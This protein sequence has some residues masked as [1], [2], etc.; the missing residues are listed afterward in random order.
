MKKIII[1]LLLGFAM[2]ACCA[3]AAKDEAQPAAPS[4]TPQTE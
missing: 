2:T 1:L 4:G 3:C